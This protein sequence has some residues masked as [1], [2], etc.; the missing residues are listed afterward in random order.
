MKT[1]HREGIENIEYIENKAPSTSRTT[2][3]HQ[4][5]QHPGQTTSRQ[6]SQTRNAIYEHLK[7][8]KAT[9]K[10]MQGQT[11]CYGKATAVVFQ[12]HAN[13][14]MPCNNQEPHS[15]SNSAGVVSTGCRY[16]SGRGCSLLLPRNSCTADFTSGFW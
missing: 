2:R 13:G 14:V 3:Q 16:C 1:Q 15:V 11:C 8:K 6:T 7:G 10:E 9:S 4:S 12:R 5:R